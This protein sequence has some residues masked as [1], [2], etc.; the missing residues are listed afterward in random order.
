MYWDAIYPHAGASYFV[1]IIGMNFQNGTGKSEICGIPDISP[2]IRDLSVLG[3]K[4][5]I[6]KHLVISF[7]RF[8]RTTSTN[9]CAKNHI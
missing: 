5:I 1:Q 9:N 8:D 7:R 4:L 3:L 2:K 6:R